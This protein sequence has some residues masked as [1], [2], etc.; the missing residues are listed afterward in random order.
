MHEWGW[1]AYPRGCCNLIFVFKKCFSLSFELMK[2]N[3]TTVGPLENFF[4]P[5]HGKTIISPTPGK[6]HLT[7]LLVY[8][9]IIISL[10][11]SRLSQC[12]VNNC[13]KWDIISFSWTISSKN[14]V[15]AKILQWIVCCHLLVWRWML[16]SPRTGCGQRTA[17]I[18]KWCEHAIIESS[19]MWSHWLVSPSLSA[20]NPRCSVCNKTVPCRRSHE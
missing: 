8:A 2:S 5:L 12:N 16:G 13:C 4:R 9:V 18:C 10:C 3:F 1:G 20:I 11:L 6:I 7:P 14:P 19:W 17:P 15:C